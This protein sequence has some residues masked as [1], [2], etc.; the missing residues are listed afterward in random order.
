MVPHTANR[1]DFRVANMNT[2]LSD[3]Y[4]YLE[5]SINYLDNTKIKSYDGGNVAGFCAEILVVADHLYS[6]RAFNLN[7][8]GYITIIF[9][10]ISDY[11]FLL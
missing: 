9:E 3:S 4:N 7:N 8:L 5:G 10:D 2:L 11:I 6:S 1:P